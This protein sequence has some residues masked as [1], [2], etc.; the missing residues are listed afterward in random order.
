MCFSI[1]SLLLVFWGLEQHFLGLTRS[2][3]HAG[4]GKKAKGQEPAQ[5]NWKFK[6]QARQELIWSSGCCLLLTS[7]W[8]HTEQADY[9]NGVCWKN[10]TNP[11]PRQNRLE[12]DEQ[13]QERSRRA[14]PTATVANILTCSGLR[15]NPVYAC[16]QSWARFLHSEKDLWLAWIPISERKTSGKSQPWHAAYDKD[17]AEHEQ[18]TRD[19]PVT[20]CAREAFEQHQKRQGQGQRWKSHSP[21]QAL[22]Q[23]CKQPRQG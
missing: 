15:E 5:R 7:Q 17:R 8:L 12:N 19:V 13:L 21:C 1:F 22:E 18:P 20:F 10:M 14:L 9:G 11:T 4:I 6:R 23:C 3:G 2:E 16:H